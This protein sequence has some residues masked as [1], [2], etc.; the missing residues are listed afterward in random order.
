MQKITT[1]LWFDKEA[2]EAAHFYT[3]IFKNSGIKNTTT[4]H[5]TP[6]GSVDVVTIELSGQRFTLISAGL[7]LNSMHPYP[8]LSLVKRRKK[9]MHC[10]TSYQ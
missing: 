1:H 8:S 10:G 9:S 7:F 4:L 3:S 5:N 2:V 6:S